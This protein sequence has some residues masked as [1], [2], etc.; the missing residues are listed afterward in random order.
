MHKRHA[1]SHALKSPESL[2]LVRAESGM[3]NYNVII[4]ISLLLVYPFIYSLLFNFFV[5]F[6]YCLKKIIIINKNK[7]K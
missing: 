1:V 7:N 2:V 5:H 3:S 6:I 4:F